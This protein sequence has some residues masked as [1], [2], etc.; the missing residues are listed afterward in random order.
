MRVKWTSGCVARP[1][2]EVESPSASAD[3][4]EDRGAGARRQVKKYRIS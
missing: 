2:S 4:L 3:T 1:A